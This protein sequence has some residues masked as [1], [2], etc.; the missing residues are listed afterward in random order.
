M[1]RSKMRRISLVFIARMK[2]AN[3]NRVCIGLDSDAALATLNSQSVEDRIMSSS[4]NR[5]MFEELHARNIRKSW[6]YSI[7]IFALLSL[8]PPTMLS[9]DTNSVSASQS[10][11]SFSRIED[12]LWT[13]SGL[14][15]L[16]AGFLVG[17]LGAGAF[18]M[19]VFWGLIARESRGQ[20]LRYLSE[21]NESENPPLN[22]PRF[23]AFC[24]F[25]GVV[26]AVFQAP[27]ASLFAPIQAF[28]LGA[29]WPAV[30]N[31]IMAG[32]NSGRDDITDSPPEDIRIPRSGKNESTEDAE[33]RKRKMG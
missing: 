10:L 25:G 30:V 26:A 6:I 9:Q 5:P 4:I 27:Q 33:Y 20:V 21:M 32:N 15:N 31:R 17:S 1:K 12:P 29:T 24:S 23:L 22:G 11:G 8:C 2:T 13:L 18:F 7:A 3:L 19:G 14:R 16:A 28:V